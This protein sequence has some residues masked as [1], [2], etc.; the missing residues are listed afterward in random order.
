M[1]PFFEQGRV[2]DG[3]EA[4]LELIVDRVFKRIEDGSY[5]PEGAQALGGT[6]Y[7]SAGP[8]PGRAW[9]SAAC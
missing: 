9:R 5:N 7:R 6:D 1:K 8:A 2:A 4:T 3:F